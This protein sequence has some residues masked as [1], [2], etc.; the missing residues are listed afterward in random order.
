MVDRHHPKI[1]TSIPFNGVEIEHKFVLARLCEELIVHRDVGEKCAGIN[2][3]LLGQQLVSDGLRHYD[4]LRVEVTAFAEKDWL[5]LKDEF[6]AARL[7]EFQDFDLE[8][9]LRKRERLAQRFEQE[10]WFDVTSFYARGERPPQAVLGSSKVKLVSESQRLFLVRDAVY[11]QFDVARGM[12]LLQL[13]D[14]V[15]ARGGLLYFEQADDSPYLL[16]ADG[17]EDATEPDIEGADESL[18]AIDQRLRAG[19]AAQYE[20]EGNALAGWRPTVFAQTRLGRTLVNQYSVRTNAGEWIYKTL[21]AKL[22]DIKV[23][24]IAALPTT[25]VDDWQSV[26]VDALSRV[27]A[28]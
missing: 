3:K 6:E 27:S 15:G 16:V 9:H 24:A 25:K 10:Y 1:D 26:V 23:V 2:W 14:D 19:L 21:R 5:A 18:D 11:V 20:H 4:H 28:A 12:P 17:T 13:L 8:T 7:A 22:A